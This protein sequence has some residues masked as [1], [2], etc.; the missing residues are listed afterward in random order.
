M[1]DG[2]FL[3]SHNV[4][5]PSPALLGGRLEKISPRVRGNSRNLLPVGSMRQFLTLLP[6]SANVPALAGLFISQGEP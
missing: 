4:G 6:A 1:L 2:F 3:P 5:A